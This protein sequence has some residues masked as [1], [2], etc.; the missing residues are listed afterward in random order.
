MT[1]SRGNHLAT[2]SE[3]RIRSRTFFT[4]RRL[5]IRAMKPQDL[6]AF[7]GYRSDPEVARYQSWENYTLAQGR[8][9]IDEMTASQPG[10]PRRW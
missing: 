3:P 1:D 2:T 8:A 4:T 9:L 7:V 5:L 6:H 10:E